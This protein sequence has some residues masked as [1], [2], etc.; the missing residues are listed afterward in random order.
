MT[1]NNDQDIYFIIKSTC[2]TFRKCNIQLIY[3]PD[4]ISFQKANNT[5]VSIIDNC[6]SK[7]QLEIQNQNR[8]NP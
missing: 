7:K 5:K 4:I 1:S 2:Y 3:K 6:S 8:D